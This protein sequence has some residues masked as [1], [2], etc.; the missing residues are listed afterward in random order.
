MIFNEG[1]YIFDIIKSIYYKAL[2]DVIYAY[3]SYSY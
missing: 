1:T 2:N 3:Y